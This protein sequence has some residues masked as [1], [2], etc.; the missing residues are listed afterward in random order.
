MNKKI[1][2]TNRKARHDYHILET[3]EA[4]I[5]LQGSEVKSL[6]EGKAN[7]KEAYV[8]VMGG[9][10][11]IIG[12]HIGEYSHAGYSTHSP[13]HDRKLLLKRKE[14][15]KLTRVIDEKG[16]TLIPL[17]IYFRN[18]RVKLEFGVAKG[19]KQFDKRQDIAKRDAKR[20]AERELKKV[21]TIS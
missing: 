1:I 3:Y 16:M 4:G 14:I 5:V 13:V 21:K 8:R 6:R 10:V 17:S 11:F 12:M 18:N 19:K 20:D 2:T 7:I 15:F 9:E